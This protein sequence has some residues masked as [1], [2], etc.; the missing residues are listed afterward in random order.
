MTKQSHKTDLENSAEMSDE[1]NTARLGDNGRFGWLA[2]TTYIGLA[3][4]TS[5]AQGL[6][7]T[8]GTKRVAQRMYQ[9]V[10]AHKGDGLISRADDESGFSIS[11]AYHSFLW[12]FYRLLAVWAQALLAALQARLVHLP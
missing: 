6:Q 9:W 2:Q 11:T 3:V 12:G 7:P 4:A 8:Q 5:I 1:E 10:Q